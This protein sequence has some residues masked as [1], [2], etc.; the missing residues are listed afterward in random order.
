ML[1]QDRSYVNI[2]TN[3]KRIS[4]YDDDTDDENPQE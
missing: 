4:K 3:Y 2:I 1:K